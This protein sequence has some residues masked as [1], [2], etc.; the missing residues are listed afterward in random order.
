[1]DT[2]Q[3]LIKKSRR[4]VVIPKNINKRDKFILKAYS[5]GVSP[6]VIGLEFGISR[7]R[8]HQIITKYQKV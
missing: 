5:Q 7:S 8:V 2:I 1:M 3:E 4:P 6:S